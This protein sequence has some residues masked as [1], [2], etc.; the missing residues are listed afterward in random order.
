[1]KD[2]LVQPIKIIKNDFAGV[3]TLIIYLGNTCNFDCVYCDRAYIEKLGGQNVSNK[4]VN[5]LKDFIEYLENQPNN[6]QKVSFHGGE[7]FLFIKRVNEILEWLYPILLRN[8]WDLAFTTNGSLIVENKDFFEKY[9]DILA[10]TVSYDF[11]YQKENR[12]EFDVIAMAEVL[13]NTCKNWYWQ[14]V[15]PI[16]RPDSFSFENIKNIVK[17]C[18]QTNCRTINVIPLRH[19]RGKD[20]FTVII[21]NLDLKQ[22]LD[23]F[24]QFLQ[25]LY[26]KKINLYIDGCYNSL[27]KAYFSDHNK[28]I[29]SPDGYIYPEFDF[30]EYKVTHM[31]IGNW[32]NKELY[33]KMGDIGRIPN[34]CISC[35]KISSCGLKYL[36][37]LFETEPIGKCKEFYTYLDY[38]MM[39]LSKLKEKPNILSWVGIDENFIFKES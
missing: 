29:L 9:K 6:I 13:N 26:I 34:S 14:C 23:A 35:E 21:D 19:K 17:T 31:R 18:Y 32:K 22:F 4:I 10:V 37:H 24:I 36:Y 20:K 28:M 30:L 38:A 2:C 27:D 5:E 39:H 7:P 15:L 12:E 3:E 25:I 1:M 11:L 33:R 8:G 16:D